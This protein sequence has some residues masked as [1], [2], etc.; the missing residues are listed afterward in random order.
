MVY[1][2]FCKESKEDDDL[3]YVCHSCV[4]PYGSIVTCNAYCK[5]CNSLLLKDKIVDDDGLHPPRG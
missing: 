2:S 1:C 3:D 5:C 4:A